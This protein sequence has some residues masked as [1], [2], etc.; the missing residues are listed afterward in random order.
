[1]MGFGD[2]DNDSEKQEEMIFTAPPAAAI[3]DIVDGDKNTY[4][5]TLCRGGADVAL[6][7][8]ALVDLGAD[9]DALNAK[10]LP[11]LALAIE[12]ADAT[13][14]RE[15]IQGGSSLYMAV[16]DKGKDY[17]NA[18]LWAVQAKK[19]EALAVI[20]ALGGAAFVNCGGMLSANKSYTGNCLLYATEEK[21]DEAIDQLLAVGAFVNQP[22]PSTGKT[23][24][25][26][27]A[28]RDTLDLLA[29]M[30]GLGGNIEAESEF[31]TPLMVAIEEK[32]HD[33]VDYLIAQGVNVNAPQ[34][35]GR[36]PL[37]R[38]ADKGDVTAVEK[39]LAAGADVNAFA[40]G[41]ENKTALH[42]AAKGGHDI[43]ATMLLEAG[44]NALCVTTDNKTPADM[45]D[46]TKHLT[47]RELLKEEE[48]RRL[49]H[50]FE[51]AHRTVV[52]DVPPAPEPAP[53]AEP[54]A[55]EPPAQAPKP[56]PE[57]VPA[58][59]KREPPKPSDYLFWE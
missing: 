57:V 10:K 28:R 2:N 26:V 55:A 22:H 29:K 1:M 51:K 37:M 59:A 9:P 7:R 52:K 47:L 20:L 46:D 14:V 11:P 16:D 18:T 15:L 41:M 42:F 31:G 45:I 54:K 49:S 32:K 44:A 33:V 35:T 27:A 56:L 58:P 30:A 48:T 3:N 24:M 25:H 5:H 4:L 17:F 6:V 19:Y 39:L 43:V 8:E 21:A 23:V 12:H 40:H 38:A 34:P 36:T 53:T 13:V 50:H